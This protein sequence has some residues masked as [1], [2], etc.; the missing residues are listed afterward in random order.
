MIS[1]AIPIYNA[2]SFLG[3]TLKSVLQQTYTDFELLLIN[4]GSTD[5]SLSIMQDFAKQD[6]RIKIINDGQNKGLI[7]R[8]NQSVQLASGEYYVRMDADDIMFPTRIEKQLKHL[9]QNPSLDLVHA[10]AISIN[11]KNQIIG[12]KNNTNKHSPIHPTV[13]AKR[14]FFIDNPYQAGFHQMEDMELWYRTKDKYQFDVIPEPLLFYREDSTHIS[15][16]HKRMYKG[17]ENFCQTYHFS[18]IKT[19]QIL[20]ASKCKYWIYTVLEKLGFE[21][22]LIKKRFMLLDDDL[23]ETNKQ[24]LNSILN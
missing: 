6:A 4:D 23:M 21:Q 5:Q 20:W 2:Q 14:Q 19:Q 12:I 8:L 10:S 22:Y 18:F 7:A 13:M 15:Q 3:D 17:L 24:T 16:K 9:M 1:I 11:A